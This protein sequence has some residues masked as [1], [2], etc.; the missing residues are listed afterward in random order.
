MQ[1]YRY[2]I[3]RPIALANGLIACLHMV[4]EYSSPKA[5][6]PDVSRY[7]P[8]SGSGYI[9]YHLELGASLGNA[10]LRYKSGGSLM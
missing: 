5:T 1:I 8:W 3:A 7:T 4:K 9:E 6:F 10:H 2:F